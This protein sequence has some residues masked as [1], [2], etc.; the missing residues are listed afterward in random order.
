[1][2][3]GGN[4]KVNA[5]WEANLERAG[6]RKPST[7][8]DLNTRERYIRDKYERRRFYDPQA[9]VDYQNSEPSVDELVT[10]NRGANEPADFANFGPPPEAQVSDAAKMRAEKKKKK[11]LPRNKSFDTPTRTKSSGSDSAGRR[12]LKRQES[13]PEPVVD[14]LDFGGDPGPGTAAAPASV[15][16]FFGADLNG[17]TVPTAS[18]MARQRSPEPSVPRRKSSR[19]RSK[20][21]GE[22]RTKSKTPDREKTRKSQQQDILNMY[23]T[24]LGGQTGSG[25][26]SNNNPAASNQANMIAMMQQ[27]QQM[28]MNPQQQNQAFFG[29]GGQNNMNDTGGAKHN[30]R[31]A[32]H[33]NLMMQQMQTQMHQQPNMQQMQRMM[34]Q[35]GG[36][37]NPNM[38]QQG[39]GM[40]FNM[41]NPQMMQSMMNTN[42]SNNN[43]NMMMMMQGGQGMPNG[44]GMMGMNPNMM[45][46]NPNTMMGLNNPM[47]Q[48]QQQRMNQFGGMPMGSGQ[49]ISAQNGSGATANNAEKN[50]PFAQFGTNA[51]R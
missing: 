37:M 43:N 26:A 32:M 35:Q 29:G 22:N 14:L 9:L 51:F 27:M 46:M 40:N 11:S 34:Q 5:I 17:G 12:R 18:D 3:N 33:Q 7:G 36:G 30:T 20:T 2:E 28:S 49:P 23:N 39:G 6:G 13:E 8:A 1:M 25:M 15:P 19:S 4:R 10:R 45:G 38:M 41:M 42:Q 24:P 16:D 44:A 31:L 50:D 21:R 47:M 48:H